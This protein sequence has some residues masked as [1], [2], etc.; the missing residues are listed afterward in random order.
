MFIWM[1]NEWL[2]ITC[3]IFVM[4]ILFYNI[5]ILET[6]VELAILDFPC[7]YT[8]R[9]DCFNPCVFS[10]GRRQVLLWAQLAAIKYHKLQ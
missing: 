9:A 3:M 5:W 6:R 1:C 4:D 10:K 7:G 8:I 2:F